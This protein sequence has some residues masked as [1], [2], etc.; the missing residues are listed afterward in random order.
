MKNRLRH[1]K[2]RIDNIFVRKRRNNGFATMQP[3]FFESYLGSHKQKTYG[4]YGKK[5]K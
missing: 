4:A 1:R 5:R 2:R 3:R